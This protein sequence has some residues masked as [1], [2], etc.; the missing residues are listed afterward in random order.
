MALSQAA[1]SGY[2]AVM[3]LLLKKNVDPYSRDKDY[4]TPLSYAAK[5]GHKAIVTRLL[6]GDSIDPDSKDMDNRTPLSFAAGGRGMVMKRLLERNSVDPDSENNVCYAQ[7]I[8]VHR[9]IGS[10]CLIIYLSE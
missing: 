10:N 4:R 6:K 7:Q 5:K 3:K 8:D 1:K 2:E 9:M